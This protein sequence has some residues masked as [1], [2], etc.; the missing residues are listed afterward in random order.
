MVKSHYS[1]GNGGCAGLVI[2]LFVF[3]NNPDT[4]VVQKE[5][6]G[7]AVRMAG[8]RNMWYFSSLSCFTIS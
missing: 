8:H 2:S 5:L 7:V 4:G 1:I 3:A 6:N